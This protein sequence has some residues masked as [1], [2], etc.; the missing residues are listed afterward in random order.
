[1]RAGWG[2]QI[3]SLA[4]QQRTSTSRQKSLFLI[5]NTLYHQRSVHSI[6]LHELQVTTLELHLEFKAA[7]GNFGVNINHF[8]CALFRKNNNSSHGQLL[9]SVVI[10]EYHEI[11]LFSHHASVFRINKNPITPVLFA[12]SDALC[13]LCPDW[14]VCSC[15]TLWLPPHHWIT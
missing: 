3:R 4:E 15:S 7:V 5:A 12:N 2:T 8:F 1:M 13:T 10:W 6:F 11:S 9:V 14:P